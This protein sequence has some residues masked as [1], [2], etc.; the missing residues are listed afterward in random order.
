[1][2]FAVKPGDP[3]NLSAVFI[4]LIGVSL[5]AAWQPSHRAANLDPARALGHD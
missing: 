3:W 4:F 1:M 5:G 2:L